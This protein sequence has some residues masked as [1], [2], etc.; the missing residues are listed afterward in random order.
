[1]TVPGPNP[2]RARLAFVLVTLLFFSWGFVTANNDPLIAALRVS[3]GLSYSE[4][5]RIQLVFFLANGLVA[6]PAA[7]LVDQRG[8]VPVILGALAL[9]ALGLGL[10]A[11]LTPL[12]LFPAVLAALFVVAL[13]VNSLQVAANPLAAGLGEAGRSHMR[14]TLAQA[15]NALGVV[16]GVRFG[17]RAM[18]GQPLGGPAPAR[19]IAISHAYAAMALA[20]AGLLV[21]AFA[22]RRLL[23]AGGATRQAPAPG[24]LSTALR[25]RWAVGGA[26]AIGAYVGAEVS[27]GSVMINFLHQP[28]VWGISLEQAADYLSVCYWGGALVG[29]F[30]GSL[31]LRRVRASG[32]LAMAAALAVVLCLCAMVGPG[33]L[34]G[35]AALAVGLCNAIMFPTIFSLTLER[36]SAPPGATSGL[37]CIAISAGA[38]LPVLVGLIAD[39]FG[40]QKIFIAPAL[41]YLVIL[42]FARAVG[43][44]PGREQPGA[45]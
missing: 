13:G 24:A 29:R 9:F 41:A 21:L 39:T 25:S 35:W 33:W 42:G 1:M 11:A 14:L 19:L 16:V 27:I 31:L 2:L 44:S 38:V 3:F 30:L 22:G 8:P 37:L 28:E 40:L 26:I 6:L 32:P 23:V 45:A 12:G 34:A 7:W 5:L 18:L 36:S 15:F 43:R 4:A 17:A 20:A 10:A